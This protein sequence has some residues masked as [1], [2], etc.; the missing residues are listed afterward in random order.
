VIPEDKSLKHELFGKKT[1][2]VSHV[3][4]LLV[5]SGLIATDPMIPPLLENLPFAGLDTKAQLA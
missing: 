1:N 5:F 3:A 2:V 4:R